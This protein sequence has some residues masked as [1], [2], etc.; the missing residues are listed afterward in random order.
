MPPPPS[1]AAA[2]VAS[3]D[4]VKSASLLVMLLSTSPVLLM[5]CLKISAI[6][7]KVAEFVAVVAIDLAEIP[8][9]RL[10]GDAASRDTS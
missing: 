9:R 7:L 1:A 10:H 2:P 5:S 6:V 4:P 8:P 3:A